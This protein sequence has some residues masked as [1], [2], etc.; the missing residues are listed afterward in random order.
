[1][2]TVGDLL[3]LCFRD[4]GVFGIGEV[5]QAQDTTDALKR[6]NMMIGQWNRRRWLVYQLIDT[7]VTCDGSQFYYVGDGGNFNI[8]RPDRIEAAF[9]RQTTPSNN[10]PVDWPLTLINS[11][12]DYSKIAIK[13][14]AAAPSEYLFYDSG[15][16]LGKLYPWPVPN[17]QYE[18]HILTKAVLQ[19]FSGVADFILLPPE[20]EQA[21]YFNTM[22][23]MRMA[24]RLKPDPIIVGQAKS[25]LNTLRK[26]NQQI[27]TLKMPRA[28]TRGP[29]YNIYADRGS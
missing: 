6:L 21:L 10:T 1:M 4:S 9:I 19:S 22:M 18:L 27:S 3:E 11:Y 23:L 2:S 25:T 7:A 14:L 26:A 29:A 16:P 8:A 24:Y 28:V 17:Y 5:P 15:F 13:A 12:E 20:Y